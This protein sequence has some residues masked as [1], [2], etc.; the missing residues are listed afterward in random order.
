[1]KKNCEENGRFG[2]E[3]L[4]VCFLLGCL[5]VNKTEKTELFFLWDVVWGRGYTFWELKGYQEA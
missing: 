3:K 4:E 1:M 5:V 2:G